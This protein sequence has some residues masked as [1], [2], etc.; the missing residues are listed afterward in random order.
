MRYV[1]MT[2]VADQCA[3]CGYDVIVGNGAIRGYDV[4]G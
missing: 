4:I 1:G 3:I 2:L